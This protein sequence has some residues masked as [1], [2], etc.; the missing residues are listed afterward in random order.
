MIVC[1]YSYI[2]YHVPPIAVAG[3]VSTV[4]H[5]PIVTLAT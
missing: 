1:Y 3:F 4:T 5:R 2:G